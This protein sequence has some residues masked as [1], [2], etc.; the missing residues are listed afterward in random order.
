MIFG[1]SPKDVRD[2]LKI[3]GDSPMP[4]KGL[5]RPGWTARSRQCQGYSHCRTRERGQGST[6]AMPRH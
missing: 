3:I 6:S 2:S 4:L 5:C 1:D